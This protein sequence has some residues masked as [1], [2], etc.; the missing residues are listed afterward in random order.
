MATGTV[1]I[2]SALS[3]WQVNQSSKTLIASLLNNTRSM[4][5]IFLL[6][7]PELLERAQRGQNGPAN[8][9]TVLSFRRVGRK[10]QPQFELQGNECVLKRYRHAK[11]HICPPPE[12]CCRGPC[13]ND[14]GIR[15]KTSCHRSRSHSTTALSANRHHMMPLK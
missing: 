15:V 11:G 13:S 9:S 1:K 4:L 8:P 10:I 3:N 12:S 14:R 6:A 5:A 7:Y 2:F